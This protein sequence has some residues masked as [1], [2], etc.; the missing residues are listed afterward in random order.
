MIRIGPWETNPGRFSSNPDEG[1]TLVELMV[2]VLIIGILVAIAIPVYLAMRGRAERKTCFANQRTIE[3][4][5]AIWRV[6]A[7]A[8]VS[9]LAGVV[10]A[11]NPLMSPRYMARPPRCPAAPEAA[12]PADPTPAEGAYSLDASGAVLPCTF[13]APV[14][15]SFTAP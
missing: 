11:A 7:L 2:V 3:S 5:V 14:H 12:N 1:F 8:P 15:G 13:G 10:N 4:S 6:D 9:D